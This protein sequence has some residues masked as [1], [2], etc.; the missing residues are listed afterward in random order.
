MKDGKPI[1][2]TPFCK[3]IKPTPFCGEARAGD[4]CIAR[5][6]PH[7]YLHQVSPSYGAVDD[8]VSQRVRVMVAFLLAL[9][10]GS[11]KTTSSDRCES[12]SACLQLDPSFPLCTDGRCVHCR[13]DG[14]CSQEQVC[15]GHQCTRVE[16]CADRVLPEVGF[17]YG[18]PLREDLESVLECMNAWPDNSIVILGHTGE[19][20]H[21]SANLAVSRELAWSLSHELWRLGVERTRTR[22]V[23]FGE[24]RP[25]MATAESDR[26]WTQEAGVELIWRTE[27]W[28]ERYPGCPPGSTCDS[29]AC[30]EEC[31]EE[32]EACPS[33]WVCDGR[34]CV[35]C[36]ED[37]HCPEGQRCVGDYCIEC[38]MDSDCQ[39]CAMCD[40]ETCRE[41]DFDCCESHQEC[42][43]PLICME[44]RCQEACTRGGS[45]GYCHAT[46]GGVWGI[47]LRG[48]R[49]SVDDLGQEEMRARWYVAFLSDDREELAWTPPSDRYYDESM[50]ETLVEDVLTFDWDGD[51]IDEFWY[52]LR[53]VDVEG[54]ETIVRGLC[55]ISDGAV[56]PYAPAA[57][58]VNPLPEDVDQ[59]GRPDLLTHGL[60]ES[61]VSPDCRSGGCPF[62]NT[63][64]GP[65]FMVHSLSDGTF[66]STDAAARQWIIQQCPDRPYP[67]RTWEDLGCARV[68]GMDVDEIWEALNCPEGAEDM[69]WED[70]LERCEESAVADPCF[71]LEVARQWAAAEPL[72]QVTE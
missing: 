40:G 17:Q 64:R 12:D 36:R 57:S 60:F 2:P 66:S 52:E 58:I 33:G 44:S 1:K 61:I 34:V 30:S 6:I 20:G 46:Q 31:D 27:G 18:R 67:I 51:G 68:H 39:G 53:H 47:R 10:L 11:C 55:T 41:A 28:C 13:E 48:I 70:L 65:A 26:Q 24:A 29:R 59:D 62:A 8:P 15:L 43:E 9:A 38:S 7:P 4:K 3:P 49:R 54:P 19:H 32:G 23:A 21:Y 42:Q 63:E 72:V 35:M 45:L 71:D 5:F 50:L 25:T 56:E 16:P 37:V 69:S 14:D 22:A